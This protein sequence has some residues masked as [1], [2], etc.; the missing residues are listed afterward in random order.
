MKNVLFLLVTLLS[1]TRINAQ[2]PYEVVDNMDDNKFR[3]EE[4]Y[5][6]EFSNSFVNGYMILENK[7]DDSAVYSIT[8]LPLSLDRN[9][10]ITTDV[11][12]SKIDEK[13]RFGVL[14]NF[15]D[16]SNYSSFILA[17]GH[18][19]VY[20]CKNG[21]ISVVKQMDIILKS[22]R[23]K[24]VKIEIE[25]K[26]S[27][28]IFSVDDMEFASISKKILDYP[29]FGY[30]VYGKNSLKIDDVKIFQIND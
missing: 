7:L 2:S 4:F 16:E 29:S 1:I 26:G 28:L 17:E 20:N 11:I 10:K 5:N 3:W 30:I 24:E 21:T 23:N 12:I 15:E 13:H 8:D 22:G 19:K 9:F 6:K 27:K 18:C 25:R 14:F